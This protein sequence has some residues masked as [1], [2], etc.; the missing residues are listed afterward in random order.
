MAYQPNYLRF[1]NP[2]NRQQVVWGYW[3]ILPAMLLYLLFVIYPFV[4]SFY[5]G[6]TNWNGADPEKSFVG[7]ENYIQFLSDP[8]FWLSLRHNLI[9]MGFVTI[10]EITIGLLL[11]VLLWDQPRGFL[12]FRTVFFMPQILGESILG[13]I[14]RLIYQPR[15]GVLY[16]LG[17][18]FDVSWLKFSPLASTE[19]AL[20]AVMIAS[21]WGSIGFFFVIFLAGLQN[22][23]KELVEAAQ[24]D[25]ANGLQRMIHVVIPQLSNVINLVTVL[26][27]IGGLKQF[28]IVWSM[29]QGGPASGTEMIATYAYRNFSVLSNVGYSTALTMV[30]AFLAL[31]I[32]VV[33]IRLRERRD[34]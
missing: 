30:M 27:L 9:W 8:L 26:A 17:E 22:V 2:A 28:S 32:T 10:V 3:F 25:G 14:W 21:I 4:S 29:T 15:R 20:W 19:G 7:L 16:E 13:V 6:L 5:L 33:F 1:T 31:I 12:F 18:I 34:A 23:D 11:A 24:I